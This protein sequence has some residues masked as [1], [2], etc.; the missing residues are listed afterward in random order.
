MQRQGMAC[1]LHWLWRTAKP[2][3]AARSEIREW[4]DRLAGELAAA[5]ADAV[6]LHYSVFSYAHRGVPLFVH[7][8]LSGLADT[9]LPLISLLHEFAFPWRLDGLRGKVWAVT[10]RA[11]LIEL[12]RASRAL[13]LTTDFRAEWLASRAWLPRRPCV[14]AP[15]FSNLPESASRPTAD[16]TAHTLGM[17]GYSYPPATVRAVLD[18]LRL[19]RDGDLET[20]LALLGAPGEASPAGAMWRGEARAR[21]L[22]NALSFSGTLPAQQLA[23]SL[24]SCEV[25]VFADPSGPTA[26]KTTLAA[27]LASG[28]GVLAIDGPR[29]WDRLVDAEAAE[30]VQQR[31]Q[32]LADG[33]RALLLDEGRREALGARGRAFSEEQMSV[34]RSAETVRGLVEDVAGQSAPLGDRHGRGLAAR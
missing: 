25:L 3:L 24:A 29:R 22:G 32:A 28:R 2:V 20:Q 16:R 5:D 14:V 27:A 33:L 30:V 34:E 4:T 7:P 12:T 1:S 15:V 31:P 8:T 23:D 19:L 17:F 10:Q 21:G 11:L 26:R 6:L 9:G 13:V 18:A